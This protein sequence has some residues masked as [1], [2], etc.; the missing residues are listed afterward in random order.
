MFNEEFFDKA[1]LEW[2]KNK[3]ELPNGCFHYICSAKTKKNT[4]CQNK[5]KGAHRCHIHQLK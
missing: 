3:K 2:R 5:T 4:P 1:S